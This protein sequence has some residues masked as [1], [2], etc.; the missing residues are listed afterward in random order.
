MESVP[1]VLLKYIEAQW[2]S[3]SKTGVQIEL[4]TSFIEQVYLKEQLAVKLWLRR[5]GIWE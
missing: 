1:K 2:L 5:H 3:G 4:G